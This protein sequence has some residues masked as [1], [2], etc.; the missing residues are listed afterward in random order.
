MA[1]K[2]IYVELDIQ[3]DMETLWKATQTPELHQQWDLRFTEITYLPRSGDREPQRFHYRTRI[4]FGMNIAGTGETKAKTNLLTGERISGLKFG[5]PQRISLIRSGSGYWKYSLK[6]GSVTFATRYT[7]D[8]RFGATGRLFDRC[9]FRPLFGYATAWSFD[10]LRI[11]L[12]KGIPPSVSIQ[13]ALMHYFSAGLLALLW[14]YQGLVPKLLFP[15]GGELAVL[16]AAGWFPGGEKPALAL[17][18]AGEIGIGLF[19]AA[20]H[21]QAGAYIVQAA[22]LLLLPAIALARNPQL[23]QAPFNP[24]TLSGAMAGLCLLAFWSRRELPQAGRCLRKPRGSGK[25]EAPKW[26]PYTRGR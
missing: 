17:L 15:G 23:L 10:M 8:T 13:R 24:L 18:G 4:G 9:L 7:Y 12:E 2:P 11:W 26:H 19:A 6:G 16:Q 14:V 21:R 20:A 25:E 22:L 5:S 3:T 1:A